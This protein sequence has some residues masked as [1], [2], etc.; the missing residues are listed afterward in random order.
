LTVF[1]SNLYREGLL[2][3]AEERRKA[4][5]RLAHLSFLLVAVVL[6]TFLAGTGSIL[7]GRVRSL[8]R[9]VAFRKEL[10]TRRVGPADSSGLESARNLVELR[11]RR[12]LWSAKLEEIQAAIPKN[13]ILSAMNLS[14]SSKGAK[15][16][17]L[18]LSGTVTGGGNS[19]EPVIRFVEGLKASEEFSASFSRIELGTAVGN[20]FQIVCELRTS[21]AAG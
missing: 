21:E 14:S 20:R 15:S 17:S 6:V 3:E 12:V 10:L 11:T 2:R 1:R 16:A 9:A 8:E 5:F 4:A 19:M 7:S 18:V 13:V